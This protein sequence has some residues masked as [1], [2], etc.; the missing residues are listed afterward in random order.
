MRTQKIIDR[1][2]V[3]VGGILS[4]IFGG[5]GRWILDGLAAELPAAV[6]RARLT[7]HVQHKRA[8]HGDALSLKLGAA[9]RFLVSQQLQRHDQRAHLI[10]ALEAEIV[11]GLQPW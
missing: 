1:T 5:N 9:N 11:T 3:R 8:K 4:D 6:I 10:Q 7:P 2:G